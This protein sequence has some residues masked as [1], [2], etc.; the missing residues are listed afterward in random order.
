[1]ERKG[2]GFKKIISAYKEY[3]GYKDGLDPAFST[4]WGGFV[5]TLLKFN[6]DGIE[7]VY[8]S[9]GD[10]IVDDNGQGGQKGGQKSGQK[11]DTKTIDTILQL[12]R[13]NPSIKRKVL[14]Q[15]VDI[16]PSAIQKHINHLKTDGIIVRHGG[17]RGGHW[18]IL[19]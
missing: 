9:N 3:E 14:A 7:G 18:E 12:T 13:D 6:V 1:M 11:E 4:P 16:S 8:V 10:D 19:K 17:D 5:L 2:S 15:T